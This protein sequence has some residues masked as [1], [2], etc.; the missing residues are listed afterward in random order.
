VSAPP[1]PAPPTPPAPAVRPPVDSDEAVAA[2]WAWRERTLSESNTLTG[3]TGLL[4]TQHA[5][6]GSQGQ[7]RIDLVGEWFSAG[8]L[9]T[10][11]FP[12]RNPNGG[13][14][15]TT[16]RL[17][18]TGGTLSLGVSLFKTRGGA[19]DLYSS[20]ATFANSDAANKPGLLQVLGDTNLGLKYMASKGSYANLGAFAE[21][22]LING[23]GQV[24]LDGGGTS[25]KLGIVGTADLRGTVASSVHLPVRISANASY[26]FDNTGQVLT[27][28]ESIR[29]E[30]VTRIERYGLG[31]NRVDHFDFLLGAEAFFVDERVRP[32]VEGH[33]LVASNRQGYKCDAANPS[34]DNCLETDSLTPAT[35]TVGVRLFP[36]KRGFSVLAAADIGLTSHDFIEELQPLPP[37]TIFAGAG[38][39][40]DTRDRPARLQKACAEKVAPHGHVVGF[41]HE[42]DK[43]EPIAGAI[44]SYRDHTDLS[45]LATGPDG[46]FWDEVEPGAYSYEVRAEGF[47]VGSCDVAVSALGTAAGVSVDC[48]L[49]ALPRAGSVVGHVR[50]ADTSQPVAGA[51]V[52]VTD[53]QSKLLQNTDASGAFR[54]DGVTPGT[55]NVTVEADGYLVQ[56]VPLEVRAHHESAVDLMLRPLPKQPKVV[57]TAHE[58]AIKDQIQF[59]LDSAIILPDSYGIL[60]EI[61]DT[62][63]RHPEIKRAEVQ[64]HTDNTGSPEHNRKLSE[65]RAEAVRA[66]IVQHG[67]ETGRLISHGY[68]PDKP[69]VP[70][71]TAL[72][73]SQNR[74][75]QLIIRERDSS[76]P[77]PK[78]DG[79]APPPAGKNGGLA[80]PAPKNGGKDGNKK[81]GDEPKGA[82]APAKPELGF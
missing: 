6:T 36:W 79:A 27:E 61:A 20:I 41:V 77:E 43:T 2:E 10:E 13:P 26:E 51:P 15:L 3:G 66:W 80:P 24:G 57:V 31:V 69:L 25:A 81:T 49:D 16:D 38:W 34:K 35:L 47:N 76:V 58:I 11:K 44:A 62:F 52:V 67:V 46:R 14:A 70:N 45:P 42:R 21:L 29:G 68:G 12:C 33:V 75:V 74:R 32:F 65:A 71:V 23:T 28:T 30:P 22:W 4:H 54:F 18:H 17:N 48:P 19:I 1:A 39:S 37:W 9:C 78:G 64:G 53:G 63:L 56:V 59:A 50:D 5:Q 73:R 72:N 7:F 60:T 82:A 8:F 40:V 55:P